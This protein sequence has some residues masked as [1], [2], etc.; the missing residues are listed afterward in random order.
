MHPMSE[1]RA[2]LRSAA[3]AVS[4]RIETDGKAPSV[5]AW[6]VNESKLAWPAEMPIDDGAG[7]K[8]QIS[9]SDPV[10]ISFK[11]LPA[12]PTDQLEMAQAAGAAIT[13][14]AH[15]ADWGGRSGY[16]SDP[17]GH[18]W[19]VAHNPFWNLADDGSVTI[20]A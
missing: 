16:F 14:P 4:V 1:Y 9:Q 2:K 17:D 11:K 3:E 12:S 6:P 8:V 5:V 10:D 13:R 7:Y 18:L 15:Q 19:E 20:P